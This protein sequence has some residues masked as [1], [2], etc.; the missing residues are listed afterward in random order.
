MHFKFIETKPFARL[1]DKPKAVSHPLIQRDSCFD[2]LDQ[3]HTIHP[4]NPARSFGP[5]LV[6]GVWEAQAIYWIGPIIGAVLAAQLW[7]QVLLE[8]PVA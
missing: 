6:S 3:I 4:M 5:A 2:R 1:R 7:E 8:K